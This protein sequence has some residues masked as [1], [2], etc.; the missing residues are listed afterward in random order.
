MLGVNGAGLNIPSIQETKEKY[1]MFENK[2]IITVPPKLNSLPVPF[3]PNDRIDYIYE[4]LISNPSKP[5]KTALS[6]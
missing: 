5:L 3:Y 2:T 6:L 1:K 4:R